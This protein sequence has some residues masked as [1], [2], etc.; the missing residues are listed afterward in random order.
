MRLAS[1]KAKLEYSPA[2]LGYLRSLL[3]NLAVNPDSRMLVFSKT[4]FQAARISPRN[5]RALFFNDDVMIGNVRGG[6]VLELAALDPRLGYLFYTLDFQ[7]ADQP[8]FVRRDSCLQ[9]I[10]LAQLRVP[11][12]VPLRIPHQARSR[13]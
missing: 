7:K 9:R 11:V 4:S 6:D 13:R 10:A 5:P 1:G 12:Q 2:G 3:E 8:R